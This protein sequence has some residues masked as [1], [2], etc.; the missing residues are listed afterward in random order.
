MTVAADEDRL[1]RAALTCVAE[2]GDAAMGTLL[3][4]CAPAQIIAALTEGRAPA[5]AGRI[6]GLDRALRT[7]GRPARYRADRDHAGRLAPGRHPA[8]LPR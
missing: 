7:V 6:A 4:T 8:A 1:A 5:G 3:R 2:P